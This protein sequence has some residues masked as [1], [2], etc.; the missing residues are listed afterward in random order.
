MDTTPFDTIMSGVI[1]L[2]LVQG[3][4]LVFLLLKRR[5][6][7]DAKHCLLI[8]L[9]IIAMINLITDMLY[10]FFSNALDNLF[11][12]VLIGMGTS[13]AAPP[14]IYLYTNIITSKKPRKLST[15][16]WHFV[17]CSLFLFIFLP[18]VIASGEN[19][20]QSALQEIFST[21][22]KILVFTQVFFPIQF[23]VYL[24][25]SMLKLRRHKNTIADI[26]S[27][28]ELINLN[29]LRNVLICLSI[30]CL[31]MSFQLLI[32][33]PDDYE[34]ILG[35]IIVLMVVI[36]IYTIGY[37]GMHQTD[38]FDKEAPELTNTTPI[39]PKLAL[40]KLNNAT[41]PNQHE[42]TLKSFEELDLTKIAVRPQPKPLEQSKVNV[43]EQNQPKQFDPKNEIISEYTKTED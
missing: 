24:V 1:A 43:H 9:I 16:W 13:L 6:D 17:P 11:N 38:I 34:N 15:Y 22:V 41:V 20:Y 12:T 7:N 42:S 30:I 3:I 33:I 36:L 14:L 39:I 37:L 29:W 32:E 23:S 27:D 26:F 35:N 4:G 18:L 21:N 28:T 10:P 19:V 8:W 5:K 25:L 40:T 2:T 31:L